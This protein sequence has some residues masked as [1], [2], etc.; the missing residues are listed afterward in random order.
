[1]TDVYIRFADQAEGV[2]LGEVELTR[3]SLD[4]VM[5]LM[6]RWG[7]YM[8]G[9]DFSDNIVGQFRVEGGNAYFEIVMGDEE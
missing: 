2:K 4:D 5:E 7:L 3:P 6:P 1:M 9:T 8:G